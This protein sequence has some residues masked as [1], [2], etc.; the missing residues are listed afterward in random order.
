LKGAPQKAAPPP[1][2]R[3]TTLDSKVSEIRELVND[4]PPRWKRILADAQKA[5]SLFSAMDAIGDADWA[6]AAHPAAAARV[7]GK[8]DLYLVHFGLIASLGIQHDSTKD[9]CRALTYDDLVTRVDEVNREVRD[10]RND[11]VHQSLRDHRD[12]AGRVDGK[13]VWGINRPDLRPS[14]FE[15]RG[16]AFVDGVETR[17]EPVRVECAELVQ[18]Q[19]VALGSILDEVISKMEREDS[20]HRAKFRE[21]RLAKLTQGIEYATSK[22]LEASRKPDAEAALGPAN[23]EA[24]M[25]F[26]Q[27]LRAKLQDRGEDAGARYELDLAEQALKRVSEHLAARTATIDLRGVGLLVAQ[28]IS[29]LLEYAHEIDKKYDVGSP[30]DEPPSVLVHIDLSAGDTER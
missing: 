5:A 3:P 30:E 16:Y 8:E 1:P 6:I 13:E 4:V 28:Q 19:E 10:Y 23:A 20:E 27:K 22:L 11:V 15:L 29:R 17:L 21:D 24:L 12:G 26:V 18:K 14:G 2:P 9:L 7:Q 25:D